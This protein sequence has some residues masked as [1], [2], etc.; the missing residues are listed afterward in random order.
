MTD[1][2]FYFVLSTQR[3]GST[4]FRRLLDSHPDIRD[5]GEIFLMRPWEGWKVTDMVPLTH[6]LR[7]HGGRRPLVIGR[8]LRR[9]R[10][11]PTPARALGFKL[12]YGQLARFPEL[13]P[14]L[15]W[16]RF[17]LI[18]LVRD[19]H[20]DMVISRERDE[21]LGITHTREKVEVEALHLDPERLR[22]RLR[23]IGLSVKLGR[24]LTAVWPHPT[25]EVR[26]EELAADPP[27]VLD[28]VVSFLGRET[29]GVELGT[30][31]RRIATGTYRD[32][33]ANYDEVARLLHAWGYGR[34]LES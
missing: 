8:Y 21:R 20:L 27:R 3:S 24:G 19:N 32:R 10:E 29:D 34:F 9:L 14:L 13:L 1:R 16:H 18:H 15:A 12:M 26:Y 2:T 25:M 30:D 6:H 4:W 11:S 5:F 31:M 28:E 33:I 17:R 23:R 7:E 22:R